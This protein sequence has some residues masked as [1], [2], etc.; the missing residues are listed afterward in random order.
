MKVHDIGLR[1]HRNDEGEIGWEVIVGG[2]LGRTPMIGVTVRDFLPEHELIGYLEAIMRVYNLYGRRDNKY[3]ARIKILVHETR[4]RDVQGGGRGR[5]C[6]KRPQPSTEVEERELARIAAYFAATAASRSCRA[7][8][9]PSRRR[10]S[11]NPAFARWAK[12]QPGGPHRADGYAIVNISLKPE[13][14]IPG[15]ATG[16]QMRVMA[17]LAERYSYRRAAREP[18]AEHRAAACEEG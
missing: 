4:R 16:D 14:G 12:Q 2:G 18:C 13:G 15:D 3:K 11:R 8:Q 17:D 10:S 7:G 1:L 6:P 9:P 5:I